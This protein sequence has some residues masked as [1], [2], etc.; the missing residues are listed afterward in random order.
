MKR[1]IF[2]AACAV[3]ALGLA[4]RADD[5]TETLQSAMS[6]YEEGDLQYALEELEYA[7]Q[8]MLTMKTDALSGFLPPAPDG[9]TREINTEINAS[10]GMMGG[11]VGAEAEYSGDN[12]SFTLTI[13]ADN[14][15]VN[16][17]GAMIGNAAAIGAKIERVGR[18][19]FM[20]QDGTVQG[21][22]DNR[23]LVKAEG[24]EVEA[25]L[26]I[27]EEIDYRELGRFGN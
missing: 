8:L 14:P 22:V 2:A 4:A 13:L 21:L 12:E 19:K 26:T 25:M 18:E 3:S 5:V 23:I 7:K 16:A 10:L 15:M 11:G 20:V 9:W 27:L 6:A 17:M 1:L 24:G